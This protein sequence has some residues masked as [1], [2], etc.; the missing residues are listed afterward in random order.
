[1]EPAPT[2]VARLKSRT[3]RF[4]LAT[5]VLGSSVA[6]LT[7]TVVNVALPAIGDDLDAS[8]T[9][10]Q[11]VVN[12][13]L[14]TL[15]S[16]ILVGGSLGDRYGRLRVYRIGIAWYAVAS[17]AC[18]LAPTLPVLV[19]ARFVQ[20]IG[21]ALLTP[22]SLAIIEATIHRDDRGKAVGA[23]SG[24]TGI[25]A[26]VGPLV[27]GLL[28]DLSWRLVFLITIPIALLA[29]VLSVHVPESVDDEG[30]RFPL[31]LK[32]A[33]LTVMALGAAS[34]ALIEG[35]NASAG[36]AA[37]A[38]GVAVATLAAL[39]VRERG[40]PG[41]MLPLELFGDRTFTVANV[42]T[43]L[44]YGG[45]GLVFFLFAIQL[46]VTAG[47]SP[48]AAGAA[49]IPV[50]GLLLVLSAPAGDLARRTGP[51]LPLTV[52]PLLIA[53]GMLLLT[54]V[55]ADASMVG[56]VLP[57][58]TTFG[59]GLS[60]SVAPVTATVLGAAPDNRVGA[61]SGINNAVSRVGQLLAVAAVPPLAGL[62]GD[63]LND[64][65]QLTAGF[66]TSMVAAAGLVLA[67]ALVS[68]IWLTERPVAPEVFEATDRRGCPVDGT[69]MVLQ[70]SGS[71]PDH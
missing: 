59:L 1:V 9:G 29:L 27:G 43:F 49:F 12:G 64:P 16:L 47:F 61:A 60:L 31:D 20:G 21:S 44:V 10:Q 67:G 52:G 4:I 68:A 66:D 26:A 37:L 53:L 63:A 46:Q 48:V 13:Y 54:R 38:G 34:Y 19:G 56:D 40:R 5:T 41:A 18:A 55:D 2:S 35:P 65:D 39:V 50:T 33:A 22:G 7:A 62:T 36:V 17:L 57:A 11:W 15:S 45:M 30:R 24:L 32:G 71:S 70:R 3:G 69:P 23:W 8:S 6:M 42:I 14:V 58:V 51:R 25:G 28:V